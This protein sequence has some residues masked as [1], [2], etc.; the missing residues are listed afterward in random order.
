MVG[1]GV[2]TEEQLESVVSVE[3]TPTRVLLL[4]SYA[5]LQLSLNYSPT[6]TR[7]SSCVFLYEE[8][9][10]E[11][12]TYSSGIASGTL[13]NRDDGCSAIHAARR[14]EERRPTNISASRLE[15]TVQ[16]PRAPAH[17]HE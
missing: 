8:Y 6:I 2:A 12:V 4:L 7:Q 9:C 1:G 11:W 3:G 15:A 10:N 5:V 13:I 17:G 16:P 14:D